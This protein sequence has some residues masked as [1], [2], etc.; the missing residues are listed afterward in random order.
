MR[1]HILSLMHLMNDKELPPSHTHETPTGEEDPI[2]FVWD[3][4]TQQSAHNGRMK[5]RILEDIKKNRR[6]YKHV[7]KLDF[8][9]K[10]L[11]AAFESSYTNLRAKFKQQNDAI[12]SARN[13]Q[14]ETHKARKARHI[15]RR[16][17]VR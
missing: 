2:R 7:P 8:G 15:S 10:T 3:K 13:K 5:V 16:K 9:K 14:R 12:H 17:T 4:T 6:F 1:K 11:E